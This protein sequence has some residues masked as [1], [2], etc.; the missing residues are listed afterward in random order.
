[1]FAVRLLVIA[2]GLVL[3]LSAF[4]F[5]GHEG[6][7][8]SGCHGIHNA[9]D[10][11]I[12]SVPANKVAV[13]PATKQPYSKITA[14][15]LSCHETPEKGGMGIKPVSAHISHPYGISSVNAKI[16]RVPNELMRDG[17][18]ECIGCHDPHPSNPNYRYLRS[19]VGKGEKMEAF[20]A[21][22]HPMKANPQSVGQKIRFF[23]SMDERAF[24]SGAAPVSAPAPSAP[25]KKG[26]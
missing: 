2:I 3:P 4:A 23:D 14:L 10:V 21:V 18:F 19:D 1:M 8:C 6:L 16:A 5:G 11:I 24:D 15:C 22:C 9:K 7:V 12:F 20:C 25:K 17:R 13:N 26:P